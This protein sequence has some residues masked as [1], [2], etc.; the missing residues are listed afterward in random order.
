[1]LHLSSHRF[2]LSTLFSSPSDVSYDVRDKDYDQQ[3]GEDSSHHDWD[4]YLLQGYVVLY[5]DV[6]CVEREGRGRERERGERRVW[7]ERGEGGG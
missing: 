1:M 3:E 6:L 2:I 5:A 4:Y 7:K